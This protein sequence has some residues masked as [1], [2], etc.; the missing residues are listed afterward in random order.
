VYS[1]LKIPRTDYLN[2]H[3][4]QKFL[5]Q[6]LDDFEKEKAD[7]HKRNQYK[8]MVIRLAKEQ[9]LLIASLLSLYQEML[10]LAV[11]AQNLAE[12]QHLQ[13]ALNQIQANMLQLD[14]TNVENLFPV[15]QLQVRAAFTAIDTQKNPAAT[16]TV[17][18]PL[19]VITSPAAVIDSE[20]AIYPA[21][22]INTPP[23]MTIPTSQ[24]DDNHRRHVRQSISSLTVDVSDGALS[25]PLLSESEESFISQP[26][27]YVP[28]NLAA[29]IAQGK[30]EALRAEQLQL[31]IKL[32]EI[33]Q[34][35]LYT[36]DSLNFW[37]QQV[38]GTG[39]AK[40]NGDI[41][42]R[43]KRY[44]DYTPA[45]QVVPD[46][47]RSLINVFPES[48]TGIDNKLLRL[49]DAASIAADKRFFCC[50]R[51][52]GRTPETQRLY[53]IVSNINIQNLTA[54]SVNKIEMDLRQINKTLAKEQNAEVQNSPSP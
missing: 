28:A 15:M 18:Q 25:E 32:Y 50:F 5:I 21:I 41:H 12:N 13:A 26:I 14:S 35:A 42:N 30:A 19:P 51:P 10:D 11:A 46:S 16:P 3:H 27:P 33:L 8:K 6:A 44:D 29:Q 40:L 43:V 47:M 38:K 4:P 17:V 31:T 37:S 22:R 24:N 9:K 45:K 34:R 39:G 20:A 7:N 54:D 36:H 2:E 52:L 48:N 1:T 53:N 49:I 23:S